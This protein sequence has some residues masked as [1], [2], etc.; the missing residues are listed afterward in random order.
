MRHCL[1][2]S[3]AT[4]KTWHSLEYGQT[5]VAVQ[6]LAREVD[7][8]R[9]DH[10]SADPDARW[11][12]LTLARLREAQVRVESGERGAPISAALMGREEQMGPGG[13][14]CCLLVM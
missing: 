5:G 12:L 7:R 13:M 11:P 2:C 8:L 3:R 4:T 10:L 9:T 1:G 6:V 14:D